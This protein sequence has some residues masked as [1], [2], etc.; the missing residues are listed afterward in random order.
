MHNDNFKAYMDKYMPNWREVRE[1][2]Q[3]W[4]LSVSI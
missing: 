4:V 3:K 2:M 1:D